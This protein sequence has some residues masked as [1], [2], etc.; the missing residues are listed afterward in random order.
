MVKKL[1]AFKRVSL[2]PG[3]STTVEFNLGQE[4]FTYVGVEMKKEIAYGRYIISVDKLQDEF[5][6]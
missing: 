1:R 5:R 3:E 2:N 4:D 6:V